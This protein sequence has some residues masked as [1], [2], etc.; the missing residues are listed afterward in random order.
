M[1]S[2]K[3]GVLKKLSRKHLHITHTH[4]TGKLLSVESFEAFLHC[5]CT[6]LLYVTCIFQNIKW[7]GNVIKAGDVVWQLH[8]QIIR[9][10][11]W[12]RDAPQRWHVRA[13]QTEFWCKAKRKKTARREKFLQETGVSPCVKIMLS[14]HHKILV[15]RA[16]LQNYGSLLWLRKHRCKLWSWPE[17]TG[18]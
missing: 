10:G 5:C 8:M 2:G 1:L 14:L 4:T 9:E 3:P 11:L 13:E 16:F 18:L 15:T 7:T 6:R 17:N 12:A